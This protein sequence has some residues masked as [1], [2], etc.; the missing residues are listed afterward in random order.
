[1]R[2]DPSLRGLDVSF[3][4]GLNLVVSVAFRFGLLDTQRYADTTIDAI[5]FQFS[6]GVSSEETKDY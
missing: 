5:T 2:L 4:F 3:C 1:M 6:E